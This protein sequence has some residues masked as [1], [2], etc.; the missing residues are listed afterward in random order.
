MSPKK[1]AII[2]AGRSGLVSAKYAL[3][4]GLEPHVFEKSSQIGGLWAKNTAI[5]EGLYSNISIYSMMFS[6]H[7]WPRDSSIFASKQEVY[8]YLVSYAERFNLHHHI[9]L[10][11]KVDKAV[12]LED[13][14][15]KITYSNMITSVSQTE[16]FDFLIIASGLHHKPRHVTFK[17]QSL[18]QGIIVHSSEFDFNDAKY[19]DKK[20]VV[21]GFG[22]SAIDAS[23]NLVGKAREIVNVFSRPYPITHRLTNYQLLPNTYKIAPID[24]FFKHP[25]LIHGFKEPTTEFSKEETV[26]LRKQAFKNMFPKQTIKEKSHPDLFVDLED[27]SQEFLLVYS[28]NYIEMVEEKKIKPKRAKIQEITSDGLIHED[29]SFESADVIV[30]CTGYDLNLDILDKPIIDLLKYENEINF[31]FQLLAY[32]YTFNPNVDNL[33]FVNKIEG[34]SIIGDE[35]QAKYI[36]LV[37][38]GKI[39]LDKSK[40]NK[41]IKKL[42]E[43][44]SSREQRKAQYPYGGSNEVCKNLAI[45]MSCDEQLNIDHLKSSDPEVYEVL[46]NKIYPPANYFYNQNK[47]SAER[48]AKEIGDMWKVDHVFENGD[49]LTSLDFAKKFHQHFK[50]QNN[51]D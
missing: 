25:F 16:I 33:A 40:M 39:E 15:W 20:V 5:W 43:M 7:P 24:V 9:K 26:D 38:S 27:S 28:D 30:L 32:K 50:Y 41:E 14:K 29:G 3:E 34:L 4:N 8:D 36:S 45:E 47:K 10:N 49:N 6:D 19:K 46:A 51:F 44:M 37:F 21:L 11:Y 35:L 48:L 1:V 2:G 31:R 22:F 17:N 23:V 13:N 12:I 18:F 42:K